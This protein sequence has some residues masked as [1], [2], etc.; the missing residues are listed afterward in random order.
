M[1]YIPI[2]HKPNSG[3]LAKGNPANTNMAYVQTG[4]GVAVVSLPNGLP[5]LKPP[6]SEVVAVN[7]NS[8][9]QMWRIPIGG[10]GPNIRNN[11]ALR[12]LNLDFDHMGQFDVKPSPVLTRE[13]F[14]LGESGNLGG[15]SGGP[16]FRAYDKRDGKTVF[17][18]RLPSLV[19]AAPMTYMH[20]GRQY[21]VV[22]VSN[23]GGPAELVALT[24][25]GAS[26]NGPAPAA[27]VTAWPAP[28]SHAAQVAAITAT[29]AELAQGQTAFARNCAGCH[30]ADG[31]GAAGPNITGRN[32]F[33]NVKQ[34]VI[35]GR[36][37]MPPLSASMSVADVDA[38][39]K[40]VVK[41]LGAP[42]PAAAGGRGGPPGGGRGGAPAG[43]RGGGRGGPPPGEGDPEG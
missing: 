11:P 30:G 23:R 2:R 33:D 9:D 41:T 18:I 40:Y 5:I 1:M 34:A 43:G 17:E 22:G 28:L 14:F 16:M 7:M 26:E 19:T 39:A 32:D 24:L 8:G 35:S 13:L 31:K 21:I 38:V 42:P 27:G 25:D 20:K 3:A 29:P 6:Y 4:G 15:G 10:A 12:G 37:E 36:G